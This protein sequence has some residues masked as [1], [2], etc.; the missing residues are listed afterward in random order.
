MSAKKIAL[1][2][3]AHQPYIRHCDSNSIGCDAENDL[4]FGALSQTYIPL[5]NMLHSFEEEHIQAKFS[6]V[7]SPV[8]CSML[9]DKLLQEQYVNW[10]DRCICLGEKELNRLSGDKELLKNAESALKKVRQ[11]KIDFT[12]KYGRNLIREFSHFANKGMIEILATAGTHAFLPHY[13]DMTEILNAQVETG[14]FSHKYFFGSAPE[15]FWLPYMGYAPG[16]EKVLRSYG[17]NYTILD[18][19]GVLF[20][21]NA[22]KT[23]IFAP[24]RCMNS[25]VLF[26]RDFHTP[27]DIDGEETG[28]SSNKIY[29]NQNRDIGYELESDQLG[30]FIT[31]DSA[32]VN[33]LFRYWAKDNDSNSVYDEKKACE[34]VLL[35]AKSFLE[36]KNT[37]LTKA[38]E[39]VKDDVC[40]VCVMN[41]ESLGQTWAEG[42]DWFETVLRTNKDSE[43]VSGADMLKNQFHL[44]R[45]NPYPC[46]ASGAGYGEDLL[47]SSNSWMLRYTRKMCERMVDLAGRFPDD[48][49]LKARLLNLGAKELMLCQSGEWAK[50]LHEG[51]SPDYVRSRFTAAVTAFTTVFDS[52]GSNIVSTDWLTKLEKAHPLFPWM[53]YRI[54]SKKM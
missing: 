26:A 32:R 51:K 16:L 47:D 42:M 45:I 39:I 20:A 43:F 24:V 49:G 48:T 5:I 10:L 9:S 13:A 27:N 31:A 33:S 21:E 6:I 19:Q 25:L 22:P 38:A 15:G 7:L 35:D 23:G 37:K 8:L 41:A 17:I 2:V 44:E 1:V 14:I 29:K 18:S 3:V 36:E 53:N 12:E 50:M 28:F 34:Q 46:A 30:D 54:F 40:L 4:F 52:L 11:N